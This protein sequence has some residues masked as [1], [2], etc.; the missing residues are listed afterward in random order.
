LT[1]LGEITSHKITQNEK[2]SAKTEKLLANTAHLSHA[3]SLLQVCVIVAL[4]VCV[5][6]AL[7]GCVIDSL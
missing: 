1:D 5:I 2:F 7:Q 4:Q 3:Y 6:V